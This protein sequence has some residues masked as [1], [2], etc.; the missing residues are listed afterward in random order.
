MSTQ[1]RIAVCKC[2]NPMVFTFAFLGAEYYC[3]DCGRT[4]GFFTDRVEATP[5]LIKKLKSDTQKFKRIMKDHI[6]YGCWFTDCK[7]CEKHKE[8]HYHHAT[9]KQKEASKKALEKLEAL[10]I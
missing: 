2:E 1:Q 6:P 7:L 3:L 10:K 8:Y 4:S 5:E 9:D